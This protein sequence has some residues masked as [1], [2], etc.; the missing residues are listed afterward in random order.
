MQP[1]TMVPLS[2]HCVLLLLVMSLLPV[3]GAVATETITD[4]YLQPSRQRATLF[5]E[6]H[7][8]TN[9]IEALITPNVDVPR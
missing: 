5:G 9:L 1:F 4:T 8:G 6:R 2:R 3:E 7:S